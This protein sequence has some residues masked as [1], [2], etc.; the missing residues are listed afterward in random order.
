MFQFGVRKKICNGPF[1]GSQ[2]LHSSRTLK[3]NV[4]IFLYISLKEFLFQ[5]RSKFLYGGIGGGWVLNNFLKAAQ[6]LDLTVL[7]YFILIEF[8]GNSAISLL[9][10]YS[11]NFTKKLLNEI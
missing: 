11:L 3:A 5:R 8:F 2:E 4:S 9:L 1:L 6:W 7:Q 10:C